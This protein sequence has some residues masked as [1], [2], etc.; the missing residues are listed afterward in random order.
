MPYYIKLLGLICVSVVS[1]DGQVI[2]KSGTM[3]GGMVPAGQANKNI[4]RKPDYVLG[5]KA[6]GTA[7]IQEV[8]GT[9]WLKPRVLTFFFF[10]LNA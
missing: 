6:V 5:K 1:M 8:R 9:E 2:D 3:T 10:R 4:F 7:G